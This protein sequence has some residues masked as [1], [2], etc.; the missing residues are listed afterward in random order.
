VADQANQHPPQH[1]RLALRRMGMAKQ[2]MCLLTLPSR[3]LSRSLSRSIRLS[4]LRL[5]L[6][7]LA[8]HYNPY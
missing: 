6:T 2:E 5:E 7:I 8:A 4:K 1:S 3:P